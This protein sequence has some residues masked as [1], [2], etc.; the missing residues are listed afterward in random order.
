MRAETLPKYGLPPNGGEWV[1]L[2]SELANTGTTPAS[3]AMSDFR[4]FDRGAGQVADLDSGTDV[5][6][7]L[8]GIKPA[9][10]PGDAITIDPGQSTKALL[11]FYLPSA[12]D[13]LALLVAQSSMDLAPS[14]AAGAA[15]AA[16][17]PELVPAK[18][19]AVLDGSRIAVDVD[20]QRYR[21]Q[22][23]GVQAP[24]AGACFAPEAA[25]VNSQLVEGKQVWLER[26]ATELGADDVLLRDVWIEGANGE[27][28]LVATRLLEAG[29][30]TP[31][32][33]APD[34]RYQAWLAASAA[35]ARDNGAGLWSACPEVAPASA[36]AAPPEITRLAFMTSAWRTMSVGSPR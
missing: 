3:I 9:Y 23:L 10:A 5:I 18:V 16:D 31:A 14:L 21:V 26:Q 28:S 20:G 32:P 17:V 8:A 33:T 7:S 36:N 24:A 1:L 15:E 34:T 11:L 30:V 25:A 2:V 22:Y 13:D 4:L 6:A 35:L 12:S 29:A 27:R 19:A